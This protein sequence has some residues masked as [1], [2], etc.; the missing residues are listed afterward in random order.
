MTWVSKLRQK[1]F[2]GTYYDHNDSNFGNVLGRFS[3]VH[4]CSPRGQASEEVF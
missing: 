2:N 3:E 1:L 4:F